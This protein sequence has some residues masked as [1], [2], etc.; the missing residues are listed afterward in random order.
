MSGDKVILATG[1]KSSPNLG[2]NGSGYHL[3]IP[4]VIN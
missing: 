4:L 2:S 3:V 1:G